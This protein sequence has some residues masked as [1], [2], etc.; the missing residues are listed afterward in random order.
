[1]FRQKLKTTTLY[2]QEMTKSSTQNKTQLSCQ[3]K[4]DGYHKLPTHEQVRMIRD[5]ADQYPTYNQANTYDSMTN[6]DASWENRPKDIQSLHHAS[7]ENRHE[8]I[9]SLHHA[10]WENRPD[11]PEE[12]TFT[13]SYDDWDAEDD[14][15][16]ASSVENKN[17]VI[18]NR[19]RAVSMQAPIKIAMQ[20][21]QGVLDTGTEVTVINKNFFYQLPEKDWPVIK[22]A[23][24]AL[25]V[26]EKEKAWQ[27]SLSIS[28]KKRT[29]GQ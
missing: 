25:V 4:S 15:C 10:S 5:T 26:A 9:Q 27:L 7:W 13:Y 19:V 2:P 22:H 3:S 17:I 20:D 11:K 28:T 24:R 8:N 6:H 18:V 16:T 23:D 1:M 21:F 29:N 12:K 14:N